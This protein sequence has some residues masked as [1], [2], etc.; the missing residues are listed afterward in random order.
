ML[1]KSSL[2]IASPAGRSARLSVVIYHRVLAAPDARRPTLPDMARFDQQLH[3][4]K[5]YFRVMPL[6]DAV[7]RLREGTLPSRAAAITFD[8]GYADNYTCALPVLQRH[9]LHATF[10]IATGYLDGGIMWN[11]A[12]SHCIHSTRRDRVDASALGLGELDLGA[13]PGRYAALQR[14]NL[15]IKYLPFDQ[16]QAA[17]EGL[18]QACGVEPPTDLMMSTGQLVALRAAGMGIGAHTVRHPILAQCDAQTAWREMSDGASWLQDALGE[19]VRLFAYPNGKP[20]ADYLPEHVRMARE[21]GFA[22]AFTTAMGAARASDDPYQL[23]RFLPW[24]RSRMAF[25]LR[26]LRNL[27]TGGRSESAESM[28]ALQS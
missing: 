21:L 15:S 9:G 18:C 24:D 22:A 12:L 4:L 23:P 2:A 20:G 16:R 25:G 28:P 14:L 8:D 7:R 5:T 11:D 6:E 17:V 26:M 13:G 3:W 1:L 27:R 10:F 19:P